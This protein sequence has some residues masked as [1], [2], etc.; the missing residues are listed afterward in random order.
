LAEVHAL[1]KRSR[2]RAAISD[3][4][5]ERMDEEAHSKAMAAFSQL[6]VEKVREVCDGA[7]EQLKT[8]GET[9]YVRLLETQL[10][11]AKRA[12]QALSGGISK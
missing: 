7:E 5:A 10:E 6:S 1:E 2:E 12:E 4:R 11:S 9:Q 3:E 8:A